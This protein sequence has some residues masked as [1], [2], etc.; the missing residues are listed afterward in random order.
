[1]PCSPTTHLTTSSINQTECFPCT[2]PNLVL[3]D[4]CVDP[5]NP[6][7]SFY[8]A[9]VSLFHRNLNASVLNVTLVKR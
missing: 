3:D 9:N 6:G 7:S 2:V 8:A 5:F 1:L 4:M